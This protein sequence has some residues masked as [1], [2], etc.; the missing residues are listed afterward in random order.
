MTI[1]GISSKGVLATD[2][3]APAFRQCQKWQRQQLQNE[4][5]HTD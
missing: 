5:E 3:V 4:A 1:V 2:R